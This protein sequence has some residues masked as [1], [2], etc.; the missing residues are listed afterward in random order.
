LRF[1][2]GGLLDSAVDMMKLFV[3]ENK[4]IV[5]TKGRKKEF[6][7]EYKSGSKAKYENLPVAVLINEGSAS[8]SEI[9]AGAFQDY[10][11]G[12]LL[13]SRSF[14]KGS[15]QQVIMLP[16]GSGLRITVAKYYTPLGRMIHKDFRV[17]PPNTTGGIVP[18]VEVPFDINSAQ[19][20]VYYT[21]NFIYSPSAK[22]AKPEITD[23]IEDPVIN[24]AVEV[25]NN[26]DAAQTA[27]PTEQTPAA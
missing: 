17:P 11:R 1:N 4:L 16:D 24:K 19:R 5:Y 25:L 8:G 12:V 2:P 13:G 15:V 9:V 7:Q 26:K 23:K 14:G 20:A 6:F 10:K 3:G 22:T 27:K 18:D 21:T